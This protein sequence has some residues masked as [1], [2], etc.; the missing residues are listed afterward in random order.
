MARNRKGNCS[1]TIFRKAVFEEWETCYGILDMARRKMWSE[2]SDQWT[3]VY[4]AP[5][6]VR[7]DIEAGNACI[8][9]YEGK[10]AAY[11]A[12]VFTGEPA[13]DEI[14]DGEWLSDL[15]YVVVHRLAVSPEV[16]GHGLAKA[17]LRHVEDLA[18]SSGVRSFRIDT[19]H[20]NAAMLRILSNL[21]FTRCGTVVY[22]TDKVRIGLEK[23]L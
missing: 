15:P 3:E 5:E 14:A 17:V 13:Y 2:G 18:I 21:G 4:P 23:L 6:D 22:D 10:P 20:D 7:Q 16:Q 8:L 19:R 11:C 9:E 12:V 1:M